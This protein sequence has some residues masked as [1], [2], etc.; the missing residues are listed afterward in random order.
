MDWEIAVS[1]D[2]DEGMKLPVQHFLHGIRHKMQS[3]HDWI[4]VLLFPTRTILKE[5]TAGAAPGQCRVST[6]RH[7]TGLA[8]ARLIDRLCTIREL[9]CQ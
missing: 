1:C 7:T 9:I 3:K 8:R 4:S 6:P 5:T 2:E